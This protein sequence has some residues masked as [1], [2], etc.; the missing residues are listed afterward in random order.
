MKTKL[1][2]VWY[3][4]IVLIL[5]GLILM[6]SL[7]YS[8]YQEEKN[9]IYHKTNCYDRFANKI[10]GLTCI[11]RQINIDPFFI[12]RIIIAM[13][14]FGFGL[15]L[16]SRGAKWKKHFGTNLNGTVVLL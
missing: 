6:G 2:W 16:V 10:E 15:H 14:C 3:A 5:A 12:A 4:G 13:F 9:P 1:T 11:E 8:A 7:T